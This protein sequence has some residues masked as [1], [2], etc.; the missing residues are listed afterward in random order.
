MKNPL[1]LTGLAGLLFCFSAAGAETD[2]LTARVLKNNVN[3]RARA[4]KTSEVVGQ[5]SKGALLAVRVVESEWVEVVPPTNVDL[6]VH[7][8]LIKDGAAASDRIKIRSGPGVNY[9][10]VGQLLKKDRVEVR[11]MKGDWLRIAPPPGAS[12]WVARELV[13]VKDP[14]PPQSVKPSPAAEVKEEV[15]ELPPPPKAAPLPA[16]PPPP[17]PAVSKPAEKMPPPPDDLNLIPVAD[18]GKMREFAGTLRHTAYFV[19]SPSDFRL[20]GHDEDGRSQTIC[21]LRGNREQLRGLLGREMKITG[22]TYWV[23]GKEH[24]VVRVERIILKKR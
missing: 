11:G 16:A 22:N 7:S 23:T 3:L 8:E 18:Q 1:L 5:A 19:R 20:V 15:M 12:L 24:P 21:Y 4:L 9:S 13:D 6:W 14:K 2:V 17:P 10:S